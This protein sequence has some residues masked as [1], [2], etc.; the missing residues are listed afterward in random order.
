M[1]ELQIPTIINSGKNSKSLKRNFY[2]LLLLAVLLHLSFFTAIVYFDENS[3]LLFFIKKPEAIQKDSLNYVLVDDKLL[4]EKIIDE[5]PKMLGKASRQSRDTTINPDL[6]KL[7]PNSSDNSSISSFDRGNPLPG[8]IP[9]PELNPTPPPIPEITPQKTV[10]PTLTQKPEPK[11]IEKSPTMEK[12]IPDLPEL[13]IEN[14]L[15]NMLTVPKKPKE[16]KKAKKYDKTEV[17]GITSSDKISKINE[18]TAQKPEVKIKTQITP[19][20]PRKKQ[21][22]P[23][24][25]ITTRK[26]PVRK[27]S[28]TSSSTGGKLKKRLN[29]SAINAGSKSIAVLKSRYG[30]YMDQILK[31]IQQAI[32]IQQQINPISMHEG[33]VFMSFTVNSKGLLDD[34]KL[35][36]SSP[37]GITTEISVARSV[38]QDVHNSGAFKPPTQEMLNDPDFQKIVINFV[39][40]NL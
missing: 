30:D 18:K 28:S 24:K 36:G 22:K 23:Q 15:A 27:I 40:E 21:L 7:G 2:I 39:F 8:S 20:Q 38:L 14:D 1:N 5:K 33:Q 11:P 32:I 35:M 12:I 19:V 17:P 13:D 34:I 4:D 9:S 26:I 29:S 31:R 16:I 6:P 10:K 25:K 37:Q 3:F